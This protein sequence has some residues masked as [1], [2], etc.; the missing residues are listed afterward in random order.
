MA[1][2][3]LQ[4]AVLGNDCVFGNDWIKNKSAYTPNFTAIAEAF[5]VQASQISQIEEIAPAVNAALASGKPALI[6][7]NVYGE[8]PQSGGDA[9]GWWDVPIPYYLPEKKSKYDAGKSEE[10]V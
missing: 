5:G 9:Y 2:K 7:V 6:E 10:Q 3:D 8:F 1:I 4:N